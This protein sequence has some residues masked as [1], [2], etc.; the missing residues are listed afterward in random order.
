MI[1]NPRQKLYLNSADLSKFLISLVDLYAGRKIELGPNIPV[2]TPGTTHVQVVIGKD[3]SNLISLSDLSELA[4]LD[5]TF[6]SYGDLR[7]VEMRTP[8]AGLSSMTFS[9]FSLLIGFYRYDPTGWFA[10]MQP[11]G[12]DILYVKL[13]L[14]RQRKVWIISVDKG[15]VDDGNLNQ[16]CQTILLD[17]FQFGKHILQ[18]FYPYNT[19]L[20]LP[21]A[22]ES[23]E[24]VQITGETSASGTIPWETCSGNELGVVKADYDA[25]KARVNGP[26]YRLFKGFD[27]SAIPDGAKFNGIEVSFQI[28]WT[29]GPTTSLPGS[30]L[31]ADNGVKVMKYVDPSH[32]V[33]GTNRAGAAA[34]NNWST[35]GLATYTYGGPTNDWGLG[36]TLTGADFKDPNF[37]VA[38]KFSKADSQKRYGQIRIGEVMMKV[39]WR[40]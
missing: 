12:T 40:A 8:D 39:Y 26:V 4:I 6:A 19:V 1:K 2:A 37:G 16:L 17:Y 27:F 10:K 25:Y 3:L 22:S 11:V 34:R 13:N 31:P 24:S 20:G 23:S 33:L 15:N 29:E 9:V 18:N 14:W 38:I 30:V 36:S 7:E 21:K 32:S 28:G 5:P 35:S